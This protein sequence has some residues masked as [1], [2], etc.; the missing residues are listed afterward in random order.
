MPSLDPTAAATSLHAATLPTAGRP[1]VA[2]ARRVVVKLGTRVLVDDDGALA[3]R[4]LAALVATVAG[5]HQPGREVI[6]VSSGAVGAGRGSLH[7]APDP[8]A[9]EVTGVCAAVGQGVLMAF[10][11][12]SFHRSGVPCGQLL[13]GQH[14]LERPRRAA[15]L[16]QTLATMLA[17][18]VV[19]VIN[20]NDAV[21]TAAVRRRRSFADND[22]LAARLA[23][24]LG[25]DLLVLL[26]DVAGLYDR[27][28]RHDPQARL[29]HRVEAGQRPAGVRT[30][31]AP[32]APAGPAAGR[33]GM[34]SKLEAALLARRHGCQTV[35]A[36]GLEA[37]NLGRVLAGEECGTWF[38]AGGAA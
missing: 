12:A 10:Y 32:A 8:L 37:A 7:L 4:R 28:P 14:D 18:G 17:H 15:A 24:V 6:L 35:I 26:T 33:G 22:R 2:A 34:A 20:E 1:P 23:V 36:D 13:V 11:Q 31:P 30:A 29:F 5:L 3:R 25:A 9:P 19:P 21:E 38:A 27:D 16:R